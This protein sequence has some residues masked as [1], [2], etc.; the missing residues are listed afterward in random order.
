MTVNLFD[1][2]NIYILICICICSVSKDH[3]DISTKTNASNYQTSEVRVIK[4]LHSKRINKYTKKSKKNAEES[5]Q[6]M[7]VK[8][9]YNLQVI[10]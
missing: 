2:I 5:C 1:C 7:E 4:Y 9:T 3:K 8:L 6:G 10:W